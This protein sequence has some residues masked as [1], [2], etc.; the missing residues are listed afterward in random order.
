MKCCKLQKSGQ[1]GVEKKV[2]SGTIVLQERT[3]ER[4]KTESEAT[5][6]TASAAAAPASHDEGERY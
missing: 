4:R 1:I 3:V 5:S 6:G 2:D